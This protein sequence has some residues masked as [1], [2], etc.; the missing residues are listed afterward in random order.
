MSE[1]SRP[2][3]ARLNGYG[4]LIESRPRNEQVLADL[5][6]PH[7]FLSQENKKPNTT[8]EYCQQRKT[9]NSFLKVYPIG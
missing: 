5:S 8:T 4:E 3:C 1:N 6:A 7:H 2:Y 9:A